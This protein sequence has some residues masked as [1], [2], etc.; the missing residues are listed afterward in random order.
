MKISF[1]VI[2]STATYY[3]LPLMLLFSVYLLFRGHNEPGGG[4][5]G[6]LMA[7][8]AFGLEM[9][10][11]GVNSARRELR[12]H[13]TTLIGTGLLVAVSSG[14]F[15]LFEDQPFMTAQWW[16]DEKLP[17]IGKPG[18]PMMFDIG[19]YL[20]VIGIV[21]LILFSLADETEQI[22]EA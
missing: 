12:V 13:P 1:S 15:A 20:L 18:S 17:V 14:F 4:F 3:L 19:V 8:A 7:S 5:V 21:S 11:Y 9:I 16:Y 10:A 22:Q 6:G 2:L